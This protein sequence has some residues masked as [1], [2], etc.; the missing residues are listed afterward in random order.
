MKKLLVL[1]I[2]SLFSVSAFAVAEGCQF[3]NSSYDVGDTTCS[4][5]H[6]SG[7]TAGYEVRCSSSGS[8]VRTNN[9]NSGCAGDVVGGGKV[10]KT[11]RKILKR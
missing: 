2:V 3:G 5:A 1:S 10:I 9:S 7:M 11:K 8:M 6:S 4:G